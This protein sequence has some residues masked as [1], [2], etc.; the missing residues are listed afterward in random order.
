[1]PTRSLRGSPITTDPVADLRGVVGQA[2]TELRGDGL[3]DL[4]RLERPPKADFGDYS[5]NAALLLA[6][7]L[8]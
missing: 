5:T 8:G 6:P 3:V 1:M 7:E 4:P 2:A